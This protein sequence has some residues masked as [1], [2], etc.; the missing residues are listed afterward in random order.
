M[1]GKYGRLRQVS[2]SAEGGEDKVVDVYAKWDDEE[3]L[4]LIRG[5]DK[6]AL[7]TLFAYACL[8]RAHHCTSVAIAVEQYMQDMRE[9]QRQHPDRM[10][11]PD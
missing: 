3:P 4:F 8:A 7:E 6:L 5:Q 11:L 9:W 2:I 10:K 1:E